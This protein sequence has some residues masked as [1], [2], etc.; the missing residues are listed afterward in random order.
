MMP[1]RECWPWMGDVGK[2]RSASRMQ[3]FCMGSSAWRSLLGA[4]EYTMDP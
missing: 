1:E 2:A 3:E 4:D